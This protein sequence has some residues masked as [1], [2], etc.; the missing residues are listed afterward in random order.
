ME[1]AASVSINDRHA[2][3]TLKKA[4]ILS[5]LDSVGVLST[6]E[7]ENGQSKQRWEFSFEN[8][9]RSFCRVLLFRCA[10]RFFFACGST[11]FS[12]IWGCFI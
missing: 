1:A 10:P 3:R 11:T 12:T 8:S 5:V 7:V 9:H 2:G 6:V 4:G